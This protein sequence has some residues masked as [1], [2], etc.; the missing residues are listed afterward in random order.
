MNKF[1][2]GHKKFKP[3]YIRK[4]QFRRFNSEEYCG[5]IRE[6]KCTHIS[7]LMCI[8]ARS[9]SPMMNQKR[10]ENTAAIADFSCYP[11]QCLF[12]VYSS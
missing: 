8:L 2:P 12:L 1:H 9:S 6:H 3:V 4:I 5:C 11:V 7:A 10:L